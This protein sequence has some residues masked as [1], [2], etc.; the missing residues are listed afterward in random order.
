[1]KLLV[2][3]LV[4]LMAVLLA[5]GDDGPIEIELGQ[6]VS[7]VITKSDADDGEWKSKT[8][9]IEVIEGVPYYFELIST[10]GAIIRIWSADENDNIVEAS[11]T[12]N[13]LNAT[14][15]FSVGGTKELFLQS[16]ASHV[17]S[18]FRFRVSER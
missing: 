8:Y 13:T 5:C 17:P 6:L 11:L 10:G 9:L 12:E 18:P 14:H 7:G 4:G 15:T 1:M 2:F 3:V 16:P